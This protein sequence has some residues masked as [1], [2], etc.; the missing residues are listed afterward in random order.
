MSGPS[1]ASGSTAPPSPL[2]PPPPGQLAPCPSRS[3]ANTRK[4]RPRRERLRSKWWP[5]TPKPCTC[6]RAGGCTGARVGRGG[7][8]PRRR[9]PRG[10]APRGRALRLARAAP[11][12][13]PQPAPA[14]QQQ[15]GAR[16]ASGKVV[17]AAAPPPR[18]EALAQRRRAVGAAVGAGEGGRRC[19]RHGRPLAGGA[20][21]G[22]AGGRRGARARPRP[23][24]PR[25]RRVRWRRAGRLPPAARPLCGRRSSC[26]RGQHG[27]GPCWPE[28]GRERSDLVL[29]P[30][31]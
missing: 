22:R 17:D 16:V 25:A 14:H 11:A 6:A 5:P 20:G 15:H 10:R 18:P 29:P 24:R 9:A 13:A 3:G 19:R 8:G 7:A 27:W 12:H 30:A 23:L 26:R 21:P 31:R 28:T 2:L 1:S 4:V